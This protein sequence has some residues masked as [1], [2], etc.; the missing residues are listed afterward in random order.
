MRA[1]YR[2]APVMY[3]APIRINQPIWPTV[4]AFTKPSA[5]VKCI[6]GMMPLSPRPRNTP[7]HVNKKSRKAA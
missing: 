2:P 7:E 3:M 6:V 5:M 1:A 4:V